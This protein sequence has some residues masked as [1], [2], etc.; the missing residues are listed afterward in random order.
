[1]KFSTFFKIKLTET[2][3]WFDPELSSD[4]P[5][6]LDP[7][8]LIHE[9]GD[10]SN[11]HAAICE[12][13]AYCYEEIK[14]EERSNTANS[15]ITELLSFSEPYEV[16]LGYTNS[17]TFG[18]GT[19]KGHANKLRDALLIL[20]QLELSA[21]EHIEEFQ[22]IHKGIGFDL[23]SDISI[24]IIKPLLI[25]YTQ[26]ICKRFSIPM[27]YHTLRNAA[28]D[29]QKKKWE[30]HKVM[31]PTNP[32]TGKPIL[33]IPKRFLNTVSVLTELAEN[34]GSKAY[35]VKTDLNRALKSR[36]HS[37]VDLKTTREQYRALREELSHQAKMPNNKGYDFAQDPKLLVSWNNVAKVFAQKAVD[38][39]ESNT[40]STTLFK[41]IRIFQKLIQQNEYRKLLRNNNHEVFSNYSYTLFFYAYLEQIFDAVHKN[42]GLKYSISM[43]GD[44]ILLS[45]E[46][47]KLKIRVMKIGESNIDG[48]F[49]N[50][51]SETPLLIVALRTSGSNV[52]NEKFIDLKK[53]Y[54][55][56]SELPLPPETIVFGDMRLPRKK[57]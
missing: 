53:R 30:S 29:L 21:P 9:E 51:N 47:I 42:D 25:G 19:S 24:N 55:V 52:E 49:R 15:E 20:H 12:H 27:K 43:E 8:L 10:W 56:V 7:A 44:F 4:T 38:G 39:M 23:I 50:K 40:T 1:M 26:E 48:I 45:S 33:L 2:D 13:F 46:E 34:Q 31:L 54:P 41:S 28:V 3:D 11:A 18:A 17:G 37:S 32:Y 22:I 16:G 57:K 35:R 36:L 5:L 14:A 6:F